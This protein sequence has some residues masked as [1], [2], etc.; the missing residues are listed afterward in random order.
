MAATSVG[1]AISD[2]YGKY[3]IAIKADGKEHY[4]VW[5]E[6][7]TDDCN[8]KILLDETEK[9]LLFRSMFDALQYV[10][11]PSIKRF[12]STNMQAW[13]KACVERGPCL[14]C[15]Y[16]LDILVSLINEDQFADVQNGERA[17]WLHLL[18]FAHLVSDYA[19]Q[20]H[21]SYLLH[22]Y[23]S[24]LITMFLDH[25][26]STYLWTTPKQELVNQPS[27]AS[28]ALHYARFKAA[29][30]ELINRFKSRC[31]IP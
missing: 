29:S 1:K 3:F 18:N 30:I 23:K 20:T 21:D 28:W 12:D 22:L 24:E 19:Y 16:N 10:L 6:D 5:G 26:Y 4:L 9:I 7:T 17:D 15:T 14:S 2:S 11:K 31:I 25:V 13:S 8:D 27:V